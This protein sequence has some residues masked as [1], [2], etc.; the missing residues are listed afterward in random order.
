MC[1]RPPVETVAAK[2]TTPNF[3]T[4][5]VVVVPQ[6]PESASPTQAKTEDGEPETPTGEPLTCDEMPVDGYDVSTTY[7]VKISNYF[8][9]LDLTV[10]GGDYGI[11]FPY[12]IAAKTIA[13]SGGQPVHYSAQ[14]IACHLTLLAKQILDPL[15]D[16]L[17]SKGWYMWINSGFRSTSN[18]D[19]GRGL[20]A[21]LRLM[22]SPG[23]TGVLLTES[24][25]VS[26]CHWV[27]NNL[28]GNLKQIIFEKESATNPSGW[29]HVATRTGYIGPSGKLVCTCVNAASAKTYQSGL[30]GDTGVS[31]TLLS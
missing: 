30:P 20:A 16:Y 26:V 19:H 3:I 22:S 25:R 15:K 14:N 17:D 5:G 29:I 24:Q 2:V 28:A 23:R 27:T 21:D 13:I 7:N 8:R 4:E 31:Y 1:E 9:L 12:K 11:T 10:G 6:I 18:T